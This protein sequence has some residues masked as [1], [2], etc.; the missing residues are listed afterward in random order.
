M[1]PPWVQRCPQGHAA[2][3]SRGDGYRCSS[4]DVIYSGETFDAR[5]HDFPVSEE[6]IERRETADSREVLAAVV[7]MVDSDAKTISDVRVKHLPSSLGTTK[8]IAAVMRALRERGAVEI[9]AR[10]SNQGHRWRPTDKGRSAVA[11][12]WWTDRDSGEFVGVADD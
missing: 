5:E 7:E 3:D 1:S 9:V 6:R 8:Q 4:C 10:N 12:G 11:D 2:I